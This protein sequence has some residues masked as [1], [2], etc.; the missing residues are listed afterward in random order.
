MAI[1][2]WNTR[3]LLL[4]TL[5][6][7]TADVEAG[8]AEVWVIDNGSLD[9]SA[10]AARAHGIHPQVI[11]ASR[12]LGFGP[13]VNRVAERTSS[14]WL[15]AANA[16]IALEAGAL[17]ELLSAAADPRVGCVAPR[18]ILPGGR[19]QHS[20]Y[21]LPTVAFTV[22]FNLGL[23]R[24][25]PGWARRMCLE[26]WWDPEHS[27]VVP[28]AVGACL[29]L[30][31]SALAAVGGFDEA[32]WMYAED[33]D[34]GW[35]LRDGGWLTRYEPKARVLHESGAATRA[36]FGEDRSTRF[37]TATY[38]VLQRRRGRRRMLITA[39]LNVLGAGIRVAWLTPLAAASN[40]WRAARASNR[41]WLRA[42]L[43]ALAAAAQ[44][45]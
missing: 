37:M 28:W 12:N 23:H 30:R 45:R 16:D 36:A 18:L 43:R 34:L 26:G 5:D 35:R 40:R 24:L 39:A 38:A 7:L 13:A 11:E 10:A 31:R 1:V 3:D 6:S 33:L 20:V 14:P 22:L 17:R 25:S 21:A 9:G 41:R 29:L 8:L 4:R 2:S 15:L 19:T 32:Q 44:E 27:Q 42:H